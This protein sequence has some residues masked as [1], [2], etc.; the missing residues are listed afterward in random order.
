M[1]PG[2]SGTPWAQPACCVSTYRKTAA[3]AV[4]A[5]ATGDRSA[6]SLRNP[7]TVCSPSPRLLAVLSPGP[8]FRFAPPL[9]A[10]APFIEPFADVVVVLDDDVSLRSF[11]VAAAFFA[12]WPLEEKDDDEDEEEE[13]KPTEGGSQ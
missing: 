10:A 6:P 9:L 7:P 1:F 11:A 3:A 5:R 2:N 13:E 12:A 8:P 4:R